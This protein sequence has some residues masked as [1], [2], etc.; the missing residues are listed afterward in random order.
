M[1]KQF[2]EAHNAALNAN[3]PRFTFNGKEYTVRQTPMSGNY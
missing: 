3:Q 2:A 1:L